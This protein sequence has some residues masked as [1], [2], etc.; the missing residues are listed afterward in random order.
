MNFDIVCIATLR[1]ELLFKTF[2]S[3]NHNLFMGDIGE[4]RLIINI[5][6]VG[7]QNEEDIRPELA[8]V[9]SVI[10]QF[11]FKNVTLRWSDKPNFAHA[12]FWAFSLT[13]DC[14]V[15]YLEEDW[16][17]LRK[18]N[19]NRMLELFKEDSTL[20]HLRLSAFP[21]SDRTLKNW[22]KFAYW[23]GKYFEVEDNDKLSIGWSGHPSM[24]RTNFMR[25]AMSIMNWS[26][27]PEKQIKG[28]RYQCQMNNLLLDNNFGVFINPSES[29]Q[30]VDIGRKWMVENGFKKSGNKA[31]FTEW[32]KVF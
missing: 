15:F 8:N 14:Y 17:L 4:H 19:L 22:N 20:A 18:V 27:N 21:S 10:N 3:F 24:N 31:F 6:L 7:V 9:L 30:I 16:V 25:Q 29:M 1:S 5:D 12:W 11:N 2:Q 26:S 13:D 23:N 32:E 28:R